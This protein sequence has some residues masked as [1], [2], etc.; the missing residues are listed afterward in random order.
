MKKYLLVI[1]SETPEDL[2]RDSRQFVLRSPALPTYPYNP[3]L[4]PQLWS[5]VNVENRQA[6]T[7]PCFTSKGALGKCTSFRQCYPY[8]KAPEVSNF[9]NWILGM[10]DTCSYFTSQG[11]QVSICKTYDD[12]TYY[13]IY[14]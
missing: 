7:G 12:K 10:Y 6:A 11:R 4:V 9:D 1:V 5:G 8:F 13:N 14:F 3:F 2:N